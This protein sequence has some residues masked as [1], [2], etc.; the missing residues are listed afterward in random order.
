VLIAILILFTVYTRREKLG[1]KREKTTGKTTTR[2][3]GYPGSFK[4]KLLITRVF[5]IRVF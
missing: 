4:E 3:P 1:R 5:K 2:E